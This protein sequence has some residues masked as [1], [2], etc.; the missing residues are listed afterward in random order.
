MLDP[1][2][3]VYF[4]AHNLNDPLEREDFQKAINQ[5]NER[6]Q[7]IYLQNLRD[8]GHHIIANEI[9]EKIDDYKAARSPPTPPLSPDNKGKG[10]RK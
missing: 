7:K 6:T 10:K 2:P 1:N 9:Q 8:N 4:A 3:N 5:A